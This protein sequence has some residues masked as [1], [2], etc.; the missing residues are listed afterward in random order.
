MK[1]TKNSVEIAGMKKAN[2]S[3]SLNNGQSSSVFFRNLAR[4]GRGAIALLNFLFLLLE[5]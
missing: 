3:K 5:N 1:S 4:D 2:V